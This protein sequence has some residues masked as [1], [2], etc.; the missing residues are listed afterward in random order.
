VIKAA[1]ALFLLSLLPWALYALTVLLFLD[2]PQPWSPGFYVFQI[3]LFTYPIAV[4][5]SRFAASQAARRNNEPLARNFS[6]LPA[7]WIF[8]FLLYRLWDP[9]W[10]AE[11]SSF[12]GSPGY[13]RLA[14]MFESCTGVRS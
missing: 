8:A 2:A 10:R 1:N 6:L 3:L 9:S 5:L 12:R 13:F 14:R 4:I 7:A 11:V